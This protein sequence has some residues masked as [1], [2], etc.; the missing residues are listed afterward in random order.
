MIFFQGSAVL[1]KG[2]THEQLRYGK[3]DT[4]A[5]SAVQSF[6]A[7]AVMACGAALH[8]YAAGHPAVLAQPHAML[9]GLG[10]QYGKAIRD[11]FA[12]GLVNAGFLA[13]ITISLSTSWT[14]AGVFGWAKSLNDKIS[15]APKFYGLYVGGLVA[16][17]VAVLIPGL[18]LVRLAV[19][20]QVISAILL[21]P[22]LVFLTRL[23]S[24]RAVMGRHGNGRF[25][26][27][28]AW[29]VVGLVGLVGV[30]LVF[31]ALQGL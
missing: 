2:M 28:R 14:F 26:A 23:A 11:L 24:N 30:V 4:A 5:G 1:D 29:T 27:A 17:A 12:L 18:P 3:I 9:D 7:L 25:A 8:T 6:L 31:R 20:A 15:E 22:L 16:A 13:A 10:N 19:A 21:A